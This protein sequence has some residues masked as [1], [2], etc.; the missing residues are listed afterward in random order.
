MSSHYWWASQ[1][2]NHPIAIAQGTLWS[3]PMANGVERTD[4]VLL[5]D[6]AAGDTVFHYSKGFL[7]AVSEV[8]TE[9]AQAPRPE[10]YPARPGEGDT[11]WLVRVTPCIT[12]L[13]IPS[14]RIA[15]LLEW[16]APGPLTVN[17]TPHQK[18]ISRLSAKEGRRLLHET[19]LESP[20]SPADE[21]AGNDY[22]KT[23]SIEE[24]DAQTIATIRREQAELRRHLLNGRTAASCD[25]CAEV[26]P[27]GLLVAGH[28]K[29][30]NL[31]TGEERRDFTAAA[32]LVCSLGCDALFEQG[33]I[34]VDQNGR[35]RRGRPAETK[36]LER[37]VDL[38]IGKVCTAH[39]DRTGANFQAH[40]ILVQPES[41]TDARSDDSRD[42]EMSRN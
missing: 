42:A 12:G 23:W 8:T 9:W 36:D 17:G 3:C 19:G 2:K 18:F 16:G 27:T 35:V 21:A 25:I 40:R 32:M 13:S 10:G 11:G 6:M 33:Y 31:C 37:A 29:P 5:K 22:S 38:L 34:V 4:R 14:D 1:G 7:R 26:L 30:R 41:E 20:A 39:N 15:Q 28:I 24:T